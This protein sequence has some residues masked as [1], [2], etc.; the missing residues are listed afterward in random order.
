[1]GNLETKEVA[2]FLSIGHTVAEIAKYFKITE[3][4]AQKMTV[5]KF[6]GY[7]TV[8]SVNNS[9]ELIFRLIP[10]KPPKTVAPR[11]WQYAIARNEDGKEQPYVQV[12][13][14]D[15]IQGKKIKIYAV[16][17]I[18]YGA[19]G[20]NPR[21]FDALLEHIG[22]KE[23]AFCVGIGD[24]LENA[25]LGSIGGAMYE[26]LI[27]PDQQIEEFREK[28]RPIAHKIF[29]AI[30]GNHEE[31]TIKIAGIDPLKYG[32]CESLGIPYIGEPVYLDIFWRGKIFTFF[33]QHG[34]SN[35]QTKGGKLNAAAKPLLTNEYTM[36][37]ITGHMHDPSSTKN[38]KRRI[39]FQYDKKGEIVGMKIVSHEEYV[40]ICGSSYNFFG[41]YGARAGY[42]P[43]PPNIIPIC[44]FEDSGKYYLDE[45]PLKI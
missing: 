27:P 24:W 45:K 1:M 35:A 4:T 30:P 33:I 2:K 18:H 38:Q 7:H 19:K 29:V 11:I 28:I 5:H 32:I 21:I 14:P 26:Q 23:H 31:R 22:E 40:V 36:F 41:T 8:P 9:G 20:H 43:T 42:N 16:G 39:E 10:L 12:H 13:L 44:V 37:N 6:E 25:L 15:G 34:K 3:Q 17:D